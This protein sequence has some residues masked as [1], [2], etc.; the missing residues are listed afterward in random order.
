MTGSM[1]G[2]LGA[3]VIKLESFPQTLTDAPERTGRRIQRQRRGRPSPVGQGCSPQHGQPQQAGYHAQS[4][5]PR[6]MALFEKLMGKADALITSFTAGTAARLGVDYASV[7][8]MNPNTVMLGMSGWGEEGPYQGYAALGSAL[9]G[10]TG[11]HAM[12]GYLDTDDSTTPLIQ[13]TDATASVTA[14]FAILAALY[15]RERT[16]Q[17]QWIDMSQVETFLHHLGGPFMDFAMNGRN[18]RRW[19][20]RHPRHAPYG[21]YRCLGEDQWL[22]VNITS[23]EEWRA[24]CA[25]TDNEGWLRDSRFADEEHRRRNADD[26]DDAIGDW[27]RQ[28][29]KMRTMEILQAAGVPPKR[30]WTT[31]TSTETRIWRRG[32]FSKR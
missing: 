12:R 6:G 11:H 18:P 25:V 13:H 22:V 17:A 3:T 9:D 32:G 23:E 21:C 4:E 1:L 2:D 10:F 28:R 31:L 24:F 30:F 14:V 20:S 29:D 26:L 8:K 19:G 16:G 5:G 7:V 27:T 15:H